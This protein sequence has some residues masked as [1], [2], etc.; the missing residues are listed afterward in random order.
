M[1]AFEGGALCYNIP[2]YKDYPLDESVKMWQYVDRLTGIYHE[3]FGI[4]LD[5]EFFGTLTATLIPPSLAI[6]V[7]L[8]EA[9][10][11][12]RQG[13]KC[14]SLGY[15]EQGNRIQDIAAIRTLGR[16]AREVIENLGYKDVQINTVFHQYMAA[17]PDLAQRAEELIHNSATTAALSG[18][19]RILIKTPVEAYKIPTL[20]DNLQAM[21]L[22]MRG[23]SAASDQ[24][25]EQERVVEESELIRR[26][27]Q[28]ILDSVIF[29][30]RGSLAQGIVEGFRK[31]F[32]DIPFSP[33][34]YNAG[35]VMTARDAEGAVRFLSIGGLQFDRELREYHREKMAQRRQAEGLY[36]E[37]QNYLLVER[38]VMQV[39][40]GK[41]DRWPLFG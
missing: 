16:M 11:A 34:V 24:K 41:Y 5:R 40:R 25:V 26:E 6:V 32:I 28:S 31:G 15:A 39:P 33:S 3:R 2:Y 22:V 38:D 12:V 9:I 27:A 8:I 7:N 14:V 30:G 10:L 23:I 20:E 29:C 37:N 1:S 18:A 36:S 4:M 17:F 21:S 19:T 13:V 35:N